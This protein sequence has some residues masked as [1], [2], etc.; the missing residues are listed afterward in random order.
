MAGPGRGSRASAW[1]A[2]PK[3]TMT[4]RV[5]GS[6]CELMAGGTRMSERDEL[7]DLIDNSGHVDH[8]YRVADA[9]LAAGWHPHHAPICAPGDHV[10]YEHKEY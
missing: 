9:I 3:H 10:M 1:C 4:F 8:P 7:A 2:K 6:S 5:R